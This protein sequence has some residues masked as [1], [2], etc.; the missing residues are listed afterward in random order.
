MRFLIATALLLLLPAE[1]APEK[2]TSY[3]SSAPSIVPSFPLAGGNRHPPPRR[4]AG[5]KL[6]RSRC[7]PVLAAWLFA[8]HARSALRYHPSASPAPVG[9]DPSPMMPEIDSKRCADALQTALA[10]RNIS[11]PR[12][13]ATC[14]TVRCFCGIH[15]H[16]ISSLSCSTDF[17]LSVSSK[18]GGGIRP[19]GDVHE[20]ERDCR[21]ASYTGCNRCLNSLEKL[22]GGEGGGGGERVARMMDRDC[23]LMGLTW[24]LGRNKTAYIPTVSAVLRAILYS[25]RPPTPPYGCSQDEENMPL[26]VDSVQVQRAAAGVYSSVS[27]YAP[28]FLLY[29]LLA[30]IAAVQVAD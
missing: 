23:R 11:L 17:N 10:A 28:V 18:S 14:D 30:V 13:N 21:N 27:R 12:P 9:E 15:L 29:F 6:D 1:S 5:E 24:L 25:V 19:T 2:H 7:C 26:A 4:E 20:L 8:A 22:K 16:Q 3:L